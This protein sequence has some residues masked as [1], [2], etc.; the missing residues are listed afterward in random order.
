[1]ATSST[2]GLVS[3]WEARN[4]AWLYDC[5]GDIGDVARAYV[6]EAGPSYDTGV[7][8]IIAQLNSP[9]FIESEVVRDWTSK[10]SKQFITTF[11]RVL[12]IDGYFRPGKKR[13]FELL[14]ALCKSMEYIPDLVTDDNFP[15]FLRRIAV[16][17]IFSDGLFW[18]NIYGSLT[19]H[20]KELCTLYVLGMLQKA[21]DSTANL[22]R[23]EKRLKAI[24]SINIMDFVLDFVNDTCTTKVVNAMTCL[25]QSLPAKHREG[26]KKSLNE[27][28]GQFKSFGHRLSLE[29]VAKILYV[30][31]NPQ[32]DRPLKRRRT[33][34]V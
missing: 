11:W 29:M 28:L 5:I 17:P 7:G 23:R 10:A 32:P 6:D 1:M 15:L 16:F 13:L 21:M 12:E 25:V 31:D 26:F 8:A 3:K 30:P 24:V 34:S 9:A 2:K 22:S 14:K 19:S 33:K 20:E 27:R 4:Y 18:Q